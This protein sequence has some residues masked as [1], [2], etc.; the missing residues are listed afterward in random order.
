MKSLLTDNNIHPT[1]F[2]GQDVLHQGEEM[3]KKWLEKL[4]Q[5]LQTQFGHHYQMT[6]MTKRSV[7]FKFKGTIDVDLLVSP[8]YES[9][10]A[11]YKFLKTIHPPT[12]RD[13]QDH[14]T[15]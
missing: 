11:F 14:N 8:Y 2:T 13:R 4:A 3:F 9:A 15:I 7:Q 12:A 10:H 5:F 1:G 6:H